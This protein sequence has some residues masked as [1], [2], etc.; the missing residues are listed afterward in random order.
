VNEATRLFSELVTD[1]DRATEAREY[2]EALEEFLR[3]SAAAASAG[4]S[5]GQGLP[6]PV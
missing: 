1:P 2:I 5:S 4:R 3:Q 6:P